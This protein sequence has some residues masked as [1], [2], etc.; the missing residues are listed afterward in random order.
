VANLDHPQIVTIHEIGH[1]DGQHYFSMKLVDGPSLADRLDRYTAEPKAAAHLVA[2]VARAVHHAHQRGILHRDLKPSNIVLDAEDRPHVTDFGLAKRIEDDGSLSASGAIVGTPQ[3]MSP[4]QAS[5]RKGSLTTAA[6]VYGLGAILYATLTGRPPFQSDSVVETLEQVRERAPERPSLI[7]ARVDRDLETI[8]LKCL[9]K[10]PRSRYG[11]ADAVADDLERWR[12]GEPI[13]A[14]RA[15]TWE[16]VGKWSRRHPAVA[17][18]VGMSGVAALTLVGLGVALVYHARLQAAY[19]EK[20]A[21]LAR[22]LTFLYQNRIIFAEREMNDNNPHRVEE[23]LSECPEDRRNWEWNY[24][25]RQCHTELRTIQAHDSPVRRVVISPDGRLIATSAVRDGTVRLWDS[26]TGRKVRTLTGHFEDDTV[27]CAF[28]PDGTRIA[29]V[30]GHFTDQD[31]L[32]VH[33]VATGETLLSLP[34]ATGSAASVAFSPDGREIV[35]ASG[36]KSATVAGKVERTGWVKVY[37]A[38]TGEERRPLATINEKVDFVAFSPDGTS[39]MAYVG[40][41]DIPGTLLNEVR[42]WDAQSGAV[43][44]RVR[45]HP[46]L[47]V[48]AWYSPDGRAIATCGYDATVR[49][50][51]AADGHALAVL[52]GHRACTNWAAFSPD[53]RRIAS[54][55][56]DG[57]AKIWDVQTGEVLITV[58]G[59]RGGFYAVAFSPDGRRLVT[60][61]ND[62]AVKIWD[63]TASPEARTLVASDT[64]AA[65][66][67]VAFSPDGRRLLTA[68]DDHALKLWEVPSGRL[69]ATWTGHSAPVWSVTFSPDG[70]TAAS[71]AGDWT[72]TDQLGEVRIWD[73][74]TGRVLHALRAH[75]AIAWCVD[76]S[77]DGRRLVSGGGETHTPGQEVIFWDVAT[78]TRLH[79]IPDV[80]AGVTTLRLNPDGQRIAV[81]VG[82]EMQVWEADTGK[83]VLTLEAN[84][85]EISN[86]T[87]TP[88]GRTIV[89][90]HK[91]GAVRVWD[92]V[93]GQRIH[94]LLADKFGC[95][96]VA[97]N[98]DGSRIASAGT[99]LT[100]KLWD[101]ATGQQLITLRG[102]PEGIMQINA[103]AFSPDGHWIASGDTSGV[104][105]LWDGS[106]FPGGAR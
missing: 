51:D 78:G 32:L 11:S 52:R 50:W 59:H 96:A 82:T 31:R 2:E 98:S 24:L 81:A 93:T 28:N 71:A 43:R 90:P 66:R 74:A 67:A 79:T 3:Y 21:A 65:V 102:H 56:D 95:F 61:G 89:S 97:V 80:K 18:L 49:L 58:R 91:N 19:A 64:H 39:V 6:D 15:G 33:D 16:R 22:E 40:S 62:G 29:S 41:Q 85:G 101:T 44:L 68:S 26:E 37:N 106:P 25:K 103:V 35:V 14:R 83:P 48:S 10:D 105:K 1:Y 54:T 7:N 30:G 63:A 100:V 45:E 47:L 57:S 73:A 42:V 5:G 9:E 34:V 76:F 88:D 53:G 104:V 13:L 60:S 8:C 23:L 55:S 86:L 94:T 72:K 75:Q 46:K 27:C 69:L 92:A 70:T 38:E 87:Y 4:E 77:P 20:D 99:D 17:A 12:R 36:L 84:Q